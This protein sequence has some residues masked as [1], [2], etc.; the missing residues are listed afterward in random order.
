MTDLVTSDGQPIDPETGEIPTPSEAEKAVEPED[1]PPTGW[2]IEVERDIVARYRANGRAFDL[3]AE[4]EDARRMT[5]D[6][7]KALRAWWAWAAEYQYAS[8]EASRAK[9]EFE[10]L[11]AGEVVR[12]RVRG[13]KSAEV[14]KMRAL[15]VDN[16]WQAQ[17]GY[18][19]AESRVAAAD[20]HMR[21]LSAMLDDLRTQEANNRAMHEHAGWTQR[22]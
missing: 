9:S 2:S 14:A 17:L 11:E 18:R 6:Q 13:E 8:L 15:L 4:L 12:F 1:A 10:R 3:D 16:V 5:R 22:T 21:R 19:L 7:D 20:K